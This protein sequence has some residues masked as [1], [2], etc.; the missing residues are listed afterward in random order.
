MYSAR[1]YEPILFSIEG[2]YFIQQLTNVIS[3]Y[4]K[5][6][7]KERDNKMTQWLN[8]VF[9]TRGLNNPFYI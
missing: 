7:R 8:I 5:D 2:I 6:N 3:L 9:L 4:Q 1:D